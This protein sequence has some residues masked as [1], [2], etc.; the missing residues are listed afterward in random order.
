MEYK[1][2]YFTEGYYMAN[3]YLVEDPH[4]VIARYINILKHIDNSYDET[5]K[6]DTQITDD[7]IAA[8]GDYP[9]KDPADP[10]P[11]Q[12]AKAAAYLASQIAKGVYNR[13]AN[14]S[15]AAPDST[16]TPQETATAPEPKDWPKYVEFRK[17]WYR[18]TV[19]SG[20]GGGWPKD[21]KAP[22][23]ASEDSNTEDGIVYPWTKVGNIAYPFSAKGW[24]VVQFK[25]YSK[26]IK[27]YLYNKFEHDIKGLEALNTKVQKILEAEKQYFK[28]K[29]VLNFTG[30]L[31]LN[32][33]RGIGGTQADEN[34]FKFIVGKTKGM[35]IFEFQDAIINEVLVKLQVSDDTSENLKNMLY[36]LR[37]IVEECPDLKGYSFT[38]VKLIY[39]YHDGYVATFNISTPTGR[40]EN[41]AMPFF[42]LLNGVVIP[43]S[44]SQNMKSKSSGTVKLDEKP[45]TKELEDLSKRMKPIVADKKNNPENVIPKDAIRF[46]IY[47]YNSV[48]KNKNGAPVKKGAYVMEFEYLAKGAIIKVAYEPE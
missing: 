24:G 7:I 47:D 36:P 22:G 45:D 41:I 12:V 16:A 17:K 28:A 27:A 6:S 21:M 44:K 4:N 48:D 18:Q 10:R 5:G 19:M 38:K 42:N 14:N 1:M 13:T 39:N 11:K 33:F 35:T 20:P 23:S 43:L 25:D 34:F 26:N 32:I 3:E 46:A 2:D 29:T 15:T 30:N 37:K 31:L 40:L 8:A 9:R